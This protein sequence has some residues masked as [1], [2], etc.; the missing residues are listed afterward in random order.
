MQQVPH[1]ACAE[2]VQ[3]VDMALDGGA[4]ARGVQRGPF[5]RAAGK[6][7]ILCRMGND[8][9][10]IEITDQIRQNP[11]GLCGMLMP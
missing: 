4:G 11:R 8:F 6:N 9:L 10:N 3:T 7:D 5:G 1:A 2:L